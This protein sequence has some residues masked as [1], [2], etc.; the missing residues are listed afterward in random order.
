MSMIKVRVVN[1]LNDNTIVIPSDY[2]VTQAIAES[3]IAMGD[4]SVTIDGT[5]ISREMMGA[6]FDDLGFDGESVH[7]ILAVTKNV[8]AAK[9]TVVGGA[10]VVS[11]IATPKQ[12]E[13]LKKYRP[14]ALQLIDKETKNVTFAVLPGKGLGELNAFGAIFGAHTDPDG[15]ATITIGAPDD[16]DDLKSW[17]I[18]NLGGALLNLNKVEQ[19]FAEQLESVEADMKAIEDSIVFA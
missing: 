15:K 16:A 12:L 4:K 7:T 19:Q 18:E 9:A 8:N 2:T 13:T 6:S 5:Q 1:N 11:S 10:I 14:K 17:A 3:G